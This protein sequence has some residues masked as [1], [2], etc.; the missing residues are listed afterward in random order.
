MSYVNNPFSKDAEFDFEL[1]SKHSI[2]A[3]RMMDDIVDLENECIDRIINKINSD[4]ESDE[5]KLVELNLWKQIKE[6]NTN[7]RRTGLGITALGDCLASLNIIYG[8]KA[9]I[10]MTSKIYSALSVG[11]YKSSILLAKERGA[12][13]I[14]DYKLEKNHEFLN[15]IIN[16]CGPETIKMWKKTGRRNIANTT[17]APGRFC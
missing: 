16:Q 10:D 15:K 17:T 14:F 7:A 1:F 11:S 5:L 9:S 12:F 4:P 13:P 3:Q 8:S 6:T 2:I